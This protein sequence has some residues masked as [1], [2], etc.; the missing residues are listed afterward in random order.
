MCPAQVVLYLLQHTDKIVNPFLV[1]CDVNNPKFV[2]ASH[3]PYQMQY[4]AHAMLLLHCTYLFFD[5]FVGAL[6]RNH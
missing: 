6:C 5:V 1:T 2:Q 4:L 3:L